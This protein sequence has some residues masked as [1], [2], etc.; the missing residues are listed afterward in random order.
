VGSM[1]AALGVVFVAE[2][3]DKTQL[4]ALGFGARHRLAPVLAG[5]VVAYGATTMSSVLVGRALG[6]AFPARPVGLAAGILLV[7]FAAWTL[8]GSGGPIG[9]GGRAGVP[10]TDEAD[11]LGADDRRDAPDAP[12]PDEGSDLGGSRGSTDVAVAVRQRSV[13]VSVAVTMFLAE[14]GDKTMVATGTL[15]A[16]GNPVLVWI[17]ATLGIMLSGLLGVM[18]GRTLGARRPERVTRIGSATLFGLFGAV[19]V[20]TNLG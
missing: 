18:L 15:A 11:R 9:A 10:R 1:L 3:G 12:R 14:L 2:L 17:G 6:A 4:V 7:G 16:R 5:L 13:A 8:W 20:A 19:L